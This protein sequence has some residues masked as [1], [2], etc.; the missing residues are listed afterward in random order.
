MLLSNPHNPTGRVFSR[1]ELHRLG[2]LVVEHDA[3]LVAD[4]IHAPLVLPG[5]RTHTAIASLSPEIAA[6]T[7]TVTSVEQGVERPWRQVARSRS[8]GPRHGTSG[9]VACRPRPRSSAPAHSG[10]TPRI[11]ALVEGRPWL[12]ERARVLDRNRSLLAELLRDH[13]PDVGYHVPEADV[14]RVARRARP[15]AD[16]SWRT[17]TA[18]WLLRHRQVRLSAGEAFGSGAMATSG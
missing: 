10:C 14:P 15:S 3:W 17:T 13:L 9:S 6:R 4:E 1:D 5:G 16:A 12:A 8:A 2:R 7:L 11:A 18:D